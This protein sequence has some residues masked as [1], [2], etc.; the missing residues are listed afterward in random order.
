MRYHGYARESSSTMYTYGR[1]RKTIYRLKLPTYAPSDLKQ[2]SD[3]ILMN[4]NHEV[5]Q[6]EADITGSLT[7]N[8]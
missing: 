6:G 7:R 8:I 2:Q 1:E 5:P 4:M 3:A